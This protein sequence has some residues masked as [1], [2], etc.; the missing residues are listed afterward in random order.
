MEIEA[1]QAILMEDIEPLADDQLPEGWPSDPPVWL[2]TIAPKDADEEE[3]TTIPI[4]LGL[5]FAH[6]AK[7]PDEPPRLRVRRCALF[8][9]AA[10]EALRVADPRPE[11]SP[12]PSPPPALSRRSL[13]PAPFLLPPPFPRSLRGV[14][15]ADLEAAQLAL[16]AQARAGVGMAMIFTLASWAKEWLR[17]KVRPGEGDGPVLDAAALA[18]AAVEAEEKRLA[19]MRAA[20]T[21]VTKAAF[22]AWAV[23]FEAE[24]ALAKAQ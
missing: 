18:A 17:A 14:S 24:L 13:L 21:P 22:N 6:T 4:R 16:D 7:Y 12:S 20:G 19:E 15:P 1:L 23:E 8:L 2:I 10:R 11:V 9:A 5:V 3:P